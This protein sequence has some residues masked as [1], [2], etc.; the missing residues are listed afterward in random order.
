MPRGRMEECK[1]VNMLS[2]DA[3][4]SPHPLLI[5]VSGPSGV[6]KDVTLRRMKE[7]GAPFHFL[8][9]NTTRPRRPSETEGVDYHFISPDDFA[10]KLACNEFLE[11]ANVYGFQYGNSR[12]EIQE[13]L[14]RGFDVILR[15]DVQGAETIRHKVENAVFIFLTASLEELEHRLRARKT[16][17][18]EALQK[19]LTSAARELGEMDKFDYVVVNREGELN[20]TA[21]DIES[22][23]RAEKLKTHPRAVRFL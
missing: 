15:I 9:T 13:M 6:G 8:V 10:A 19:R 11:F 12:S 16:E 17:S 1:S 2:S 21:E 23:I 5:V 4:P 20:R 22:I 18:E 3:P 14:A 7:R